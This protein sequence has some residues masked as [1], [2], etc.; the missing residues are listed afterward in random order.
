MIPLLPRE[1]LGLEEYL[2]TV[3][4]VIFTLIYLC[5]SVVTQGE[6][7]ELFEGVSSPCGSWGSDLGPQ[8]WQPN[9]YYNPSQSFPLFKTS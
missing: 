6:D 8:A 2:L 5:A 3:V 1:G 7:R 4:L 9:L